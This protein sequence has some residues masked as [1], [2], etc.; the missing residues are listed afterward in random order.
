MRRDTYNVRDMKRVQMTV[1]LPVP[2]SNTAI[3][4]AFCD[5]A[6]IYVYD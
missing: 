6:P 3:I 2:V 5:P 4:R 1:V